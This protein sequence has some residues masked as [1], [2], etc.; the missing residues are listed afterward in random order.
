MK[1][2]KKVV[3]AAFAFA[4]VLTGCS[5]VAVESAASGI[6]A[7]SR[8]VA[9]N[10]H[11]F[12]LYSDMNPGFGNAVYFTGTFAE[13]KEWKVAV[14]G[15]YENGWYADVTSYE[16]F[17]W[18]ALTGA[19]ALGETVADFTQLAW[20][21]GSNHCAEVA[22]PA[23]PANRFVITGSGYNHYGQCFY[24]TGNFQEGNNWNTAVN[25]SWLG[26]YKNYAVV[27]ADSKYFEWKQLYGFGYHG[28]VAEAP[29]EGLSW[30]D[31]NNNTCGYDFKEFLESQSVLNSSGWYDP[32]KSLAHV[33]CGGIY[34]DEISQYI[35]GVKVSVFC[36]SEKVSEKVVEFNDYASATLSADEIAGNGEF[37]VKVAFVNVWG[38]TSP[39]LTAVTFSK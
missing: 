11:E 9:V 31:G 35:A 13:G 26:W 27:T 5:E 30:R 1:N 36:G 14:R 12:R 24:F 39:A 23:I 3:V 17:E 10:S 20:E 29:Y 22:G 28:E 18:K 16:N 25:C 2:L 21:N 15:T 7:S 6:E 33:S 8:A 19:Y 4:A 37:E 38:T 34:N 32:E